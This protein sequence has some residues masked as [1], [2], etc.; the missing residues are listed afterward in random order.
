MAVGVTL[1]I[2]DQFTSSLYFV[3]C[4]NILLIISLLMLIS[5]FMNSMKSMWYYVM[6]VLYPNLRGLKTEETQNEHP[7]GKG[8]KIYFSHP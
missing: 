2:P 3:L 7:V 1:T 6:N 8:I 5:N 4:D